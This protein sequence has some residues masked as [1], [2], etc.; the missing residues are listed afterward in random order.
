MNRPFLCRMEDIAPTGAKGVVLGEGEDALDIVVVGK[1][2]AHYAYVNSCPHQFVPLE[3]FPD[4][5]LTRDRTYLVCSGHGARFAPDSGKCVS[6]P[7]I[8]ERLDR[9]EICEADGALY[10]AEELS[11]QEIARSKRRFRNW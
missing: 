7:C 1:D 5:F 2:G 6:G 4:H 9:L 10:L 3:T 11:P 8:G